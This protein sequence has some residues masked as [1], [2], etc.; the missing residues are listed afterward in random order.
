MTQ[1]RILIAVALLLAS[2][3]LVLSLNKTGKDG[4]RNETGQ[5]PQE[6]RLSFKGETGPYPFKTVAG[7]YL[8][9]RFAQ[10]NADWGQA[11]DYISDLIPVETTNLELKRRAMVLAMGSGHS[12][13]AF[14]LAQDLVKAGDNGSLPRVFLTLQN[15]KSGKYRDTLQQMGAVPKDGISEFVN[16]LIYSWAK[17]GTGQADVSALNQN[18]VHIYHAILIADYLNN[19]EALKKLA[20]Q[21]LTRLNLAAKSLERIADIFAR[22]KLGP[23]AQALYTYVRNSNPEAA[24]AITEKVAAMEKSGTP[25]PAPDDRIASPIEGLAQALFDMA[26]VLY[27]DYPDSA[28]LFAQMSLYLNPTLNDARILLGHMA[29]QAERYDE[30]IAF[31]Q[32][33]NPRGDEKMEIKLQ[34]QV[35]ELLENSE[36]SDQA[37]AVLEKLV[38]RTNDLDTQIQLGDIYRHKENYVQALAAYNR[39]FA[40]LDNHVP[41][42]YWNL[43][44]ARGMTNERL[45][46]WEQAEKDLKAALAYEPDHPY[47]LNY[48]G[49]SWADQGINLDKAAEMIARAV[50]LRPGDGSIVDS[51]G[52][53]YYRMKKYQ[54]AVTT[55]ENAV[56]LMPYD[57][58]V[59]DHLG[60]AY[61]Q[62]GRR[63]EARFQ[64]KRALS[65]SREAETTAAIEEKLQRGLL[66]SG[67]ASSS[68]LHPQQKQAENHPPE[69][70][71]GKPD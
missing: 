6:T 8:A 28:R 5:L 26:S 50:R 32:Q 27:G 1:K 59:N 64:W 9:G 7:S 29:A 19:S 34:R 62:V 67:D 41:Q 17:A 23:Q 4:F 51:L 53:V 49:Y 71:P 57:A 20:Q 10:N 52:W 60:D 55:L 39:A 37:I 61:W 13:Q 40:M 45:K 42:Q 54:E 66:T 43:I 48:L 3:A 14:A 69:A 44:Y 46:N 16:P 33:I 36:R 2:S 11:Y 58:T 21:D 68:P 70:V 18:V 38:A 31:Y 25:P 65:F 24:K 15:F 47:I 35:A 56:E 12:D 30:A 22:H 63:S